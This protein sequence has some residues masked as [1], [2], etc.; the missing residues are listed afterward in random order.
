[1]ATVVDAGPWQVNS[2]GH[3]ANRLRR[4][5]HGAD[6]ELLVPDAN[7]RRALWTPASDP[8]ASSEVRSPGPGGARAA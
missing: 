3:A 2:P 8:A 7:R 6:R 5:R 4:R 1:M